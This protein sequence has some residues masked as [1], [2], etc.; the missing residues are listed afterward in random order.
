[1]KS[2]LLVEYDESLNIGISLKLNK[3]SMRAFS[4]LYRRNVIYL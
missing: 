2:I 1:M 4:E 3:E